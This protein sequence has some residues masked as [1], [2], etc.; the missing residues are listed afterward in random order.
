MSDR[1]PLPPRLA[2]LLEAPPARVLW[3]LTT[4][5]VATTVLMSGV[6]FADAWFVGQLGDRKS[7]V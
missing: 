4:P 5:N 2:L 1:K 7:V 6:T 3:R